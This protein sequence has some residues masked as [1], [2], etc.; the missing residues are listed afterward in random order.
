MT[1]TRRGLL[2]S[3]LS[4]AG[5]AAL[6][7]G[8]G[9]LG[10]AGLAGCAGAPR[11]VQSAQVRFQLEPDTARVYTDERFLGGARVVATRPIELR[12][13]P[14]RFTITA[15]GYFPH[16]LEVDLPPGVT[17]IRVSLR[18]VPR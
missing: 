5:S 8:A 10:C 9:L 18:P 6:L 2:G 13:G 17:T 1:S 14:R 16:D 11:P 15:E 12:T 4:L 3:A 7:G